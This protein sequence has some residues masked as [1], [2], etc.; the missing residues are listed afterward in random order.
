MS[1][2]IGLKVPISFDDLSSRRHWLRL[3]QELAHFDIRACSL[4]VLD[5]AQY[6][7]INDEVV[8]AERCFVPPDDD[9]SKQTPDPVTYPLIFN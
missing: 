1:I 6:F 7:R 4:N 5:S 3:F 8:V 2:A 9:A